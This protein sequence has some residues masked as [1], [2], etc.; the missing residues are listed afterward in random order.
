M[1]YTSLF[2]VIVA[3]SYYASSICDCLRYKANADTQKFIDK[4]GLVMRLTNNGF[5]LYTTTNQSI[6]DY[7]NDITQVS[8]TTAFDFFDRLLCLVGKCRVSQAAS[9]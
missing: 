7:L 8:E 6:E 4:Y 5:E 9:R 3:H 2:K 1:T